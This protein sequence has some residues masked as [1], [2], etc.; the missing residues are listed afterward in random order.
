MILALSRWDGK[1]SST[2][3]SLA[4]VFAREH[5]V[6]YLD[7]PFTIKDVLL[8]L[9][10]RQ[11]WRRLPALLFG[12][13]SFSRPIPGIP[14]FV[15]VTPRM[16]WS[17]NWLPKG[18]LFHALARIN[19]KIVFHVISKTINKF[20][21]RDFAYINSFNPLYGNHFPDDFWP[22]PSIYHC[23]D[24]I[25]KSP[26][27]AKHGT[28]EEKVAAQKADLV[29]TT[30]GELARL[31]SDQNDQVEV[32]PNAADVRLF[33]RAMNET[34]S[35]PPELSKLPKDKKVV[36]YCGN[37][38]HR[39]DYQL[40]VKI[41]ERLTNHI[42]LMVGPI[43]SDAYRQHRLHKHANVVFTGKKKLEQLPAY[44]QHSHCAIIP[45]LCNTLT[46]SIYPLKVNEYLSAGKPVV[47]TPFSEEIKGF[48]GV[49]SVA[50][51]HEAFIREVRQSIIMDD[52]YKQEMRMEF[53]ASNSWEDRA[54]KF[55]KVLTKQRSW[56][57]TPNPI[58]T[59]A[60]NPTRNLSDC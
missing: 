4:K 20:Q 3:L 60:S 38:C 5:R 46:R 47:T 55:L 54:S 58:Q 31:K 35:V 49:V 42:L 12:W 6:F 7:N 2:I 56:Q 34:L 39:L 22:R 15:V 8:G 17:I 48:G 25:S 27:V 16:T 57:N 50:D 51:S 21:L 36:V 11:I 33:Q 32:I 45:F 14:N 43:S 18:K 37:I 19:D 41:A 40:L 13:N 23:V 26:Y 9:G 44:L 30:S 52:D 29:V 24:D 10:T 53:A 1:Y 28:R 59:D